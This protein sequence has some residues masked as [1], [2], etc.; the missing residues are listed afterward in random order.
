[1]RGDSMP[2]E[3]VSL[4]LAPFENILR[5]A[6]VARVSK[7]GAREFVSWIEETARDRAGDINRIALHNGRKTVTD[8]DVR[9]EKSLKR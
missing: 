5:E 7:A 3:T 6:G 1:M 2:K 8:K 9:L 4:P